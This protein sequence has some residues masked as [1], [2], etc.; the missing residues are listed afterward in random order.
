MSTYRPEME[1]RRSYLDLIFSYATEVMNGKSKKSKVD[2]EPHGSM[3]QR[4]S[5]PR[6]LALSQTCRDIADNAVC[7]F[8]SRFRCYSLHLSTEE[9]S[10]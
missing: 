2:R 1:L 8:A 9:W 7:L 6:V 5:D 3:E 4:C 10:S